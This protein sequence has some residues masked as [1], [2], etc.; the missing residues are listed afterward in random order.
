MDSPLQANL[1]VKEVLE[2]HP[3][4]IPAFLALRTRCVGCHMGRFCTLEDVTQV[5][6]LSLQVLLDK[7]QESIQS[8]EKE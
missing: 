6:E 1:T 7:L 5:Y 4:T 2:I 3:G 8:Q